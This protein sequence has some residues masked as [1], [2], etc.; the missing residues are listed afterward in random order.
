MPATQPA[1]DSAAIWRFAPSER[2]A[3]FTDAFGAIARDL[4][5][6]LRQ[7]LPSRYFLP[8]D[9][10]LDRRR[11]LAMLVYQCSRPTPRRRGRE[12]T[13]DIV[14]RAMMAGFYWGVRQVL[15][16]ELAWLQ[17]HMLTAGRYTQ[18]RAYA[19]RHSAAIVAEV[20][21]HPQLLGRLLSAE[22]SLVRDLLQFAEAFP[23]EDSPLRAA[24]LRDNLLHSWTRTLSRVYPSLDA[25][26]LAG[27]LFESA[28]RI[29]AGFGQRTFAAAA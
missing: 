9:S 3:A 15:P 4:Q 16:A 24:R 18:A 1:F 5:Q 12:F 13:Y 27:G 19:P 23:R 14:D 7:Q 11:S 22:G 10:H 28:T 29:M 21:A 25:S 2:A 6:S 17:A 8:A 20:R 26:G